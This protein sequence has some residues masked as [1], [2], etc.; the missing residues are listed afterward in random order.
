M[1]LRKFVDKYGGDGL[2]KRIR[3]NCLKNDPTIP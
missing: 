2:A 1:M 3:I